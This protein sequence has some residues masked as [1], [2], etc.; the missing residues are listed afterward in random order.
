MAIKQKQGPDQSPAAVAHKSAGILATSGMPDRIWYSCGLTLNLGNYESARVDA[1]MATDLHHGE[2]LD[3]ALQRCK[4]FVTH[5]VEGQAVDVRS[6]LYEKTGEEQ[7]P[8]P[9]F[10]KAGRTTTK[11]KRSY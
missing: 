10:N 5:E 11:K 9:K 6:S 1:G 3:D 7:R 8:A 2:S 4:D